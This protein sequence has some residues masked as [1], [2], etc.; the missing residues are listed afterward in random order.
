MKKGS[1]GDIMIFFVINE[2]NTVYGVYLT[3]STLECD[4]VQEEYILSGHKV[5]IF[6]A[7]VLLL[8][9]IIFS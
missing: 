2:T 6:Y 9:F 1:D 5:F 7:S 3:I 8:Y 4:D